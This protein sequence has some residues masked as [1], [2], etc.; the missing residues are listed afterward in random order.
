MWYKCYNPPLP[1]NNEN[2]NQ[3][4]ILWD[5]IK[6]VEFNEYVNYSCAGFSEK[7]ET[8]FEHDKDLQYF[9]I[10]CQ[11]DGYFEIPDQWFRCVKGIKLLIPSTA[12]KSN[13]CKKSNPKK[14]LILQFI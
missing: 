1:P 6:P 2:R 3:L 10:K 7:Y 8:F 4:N 12:T 14:F 9:S 11:D 5:P 13:Y